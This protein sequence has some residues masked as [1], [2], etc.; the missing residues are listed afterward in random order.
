MSISKVRV[1]W[2]LLVLASTAPA[3]ADK[4]EYFLEVVNP[5]CEMGFYKKSARRFKKS[6]KPL[7]TLVNKTLIGRRLESTKRLAVFR[8]LEDQDKELYAAEANC[9]IKGPAYDPDAPDIEAIKITDARDLKIEDIDSDQTPSRPGYYYV[10]LLTWQ[11]AVSVVQKAN[12]IVPRTAYPAA[13]S[14]AVVCPGFGKYFMDFGSSVLAWDT[15]IAPIGTSEIGYRGAQ[16]GA[17]IFRSKSARVLA[18]MTGPVWNLKISEKL[19]LG[20]NLPFTLRFVNLPH[21][22]SASYERPSERTFFPSYL[23]SAQY[24]RNS[25]V[26]IYKVGMVK[27]WPGYTFGVQVGKTF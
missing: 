2:G 12:G 24:I 22:D 17:P 14:A 6:F 13:V 11:E 27:T 8:I 19:S 9:F 5:R 16:P 23:L 25:W 3:M 10:A 1:L 26:Y 18:V 4:G 21:L 7:S 20:F 15:C